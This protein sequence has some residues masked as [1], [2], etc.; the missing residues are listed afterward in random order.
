MRPKISVAICTHNPRRSYLQ[1]TLDGLRAQTL[2]T[3]EWELMLIDNR[4]DEPRAGPISP[5]IL[6]QGSSAKRNLV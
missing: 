1:Q 3:T 4:S 6:R 5:G 2:P